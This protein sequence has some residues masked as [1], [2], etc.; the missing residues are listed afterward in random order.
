MSLTTIQA[1]SLVRDGVAD[2][3]GGRPRDARARFEQVIA[4]DTS[5]PRPWLLLA[6]ACHHMGDR[7]A[8][9]Q[10]LD[11]LLANEMRSLPGLLMKAEARSAA[12]DDRG[13]TAFYRTALNVAGQMESVPQMLIPMLQRGEAHLKAASA[14]Y[15]AHLTERLSAAAGKPSGLS[16]RVRQ[17]VE[18]LLG[19]SQ[20]YLQQPTMFYFPGLPQRQF[21]E[22]EEFPW[23]GEIENMLPALQEELHGILAETDEFAPYVEGNAERPRPNN[24]LLNDPS[25]GAF[26]F[27]R[28]GAKVEENA[29]RCP[30]TMAALAKAPMPNISGRSPMALYSVLKPGTHIASHHGALNTRLICHVPL[31]VP[32]DCA[33]RVGS[34]TRA[35]EEG[36]ALIFD[37]SFEHEAWNRSANTRVILLFEVWRPEISV[38]EREE[39]TALFSAIDDYQGAPDPGD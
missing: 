7:E 22:R 36:K 21:Y 33:L 27:W 24:H 29:A 34:E 1:E 26:Y 13:A 8:E 28:N 10:A 16:R 3:R 2:L 25:W 14:R 31:L 37:D 30:Q 9:E 15:E 20:L 11:Q 4:S 6:Q 19:K 17:S 39:L 38:N 35:W 5:L 32:G 18:M 12:G 23:V